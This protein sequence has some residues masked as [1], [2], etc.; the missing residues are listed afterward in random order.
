[1]TPAIQTARMIQWRGVKRGEKRPRQTEKKND[2]QDD[3]HFRGVSTD[4]IGARPVRTHSSVTGP[5]ADGFLR[6]TRAASRQ[7]FHTA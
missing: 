7:N 5:D 6:T 1:M 2:G 3:A 4:E